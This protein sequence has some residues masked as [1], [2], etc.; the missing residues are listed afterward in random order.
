MNKL[1]IILAFGFWPWSSP[2]V[3]VV[4]AVSETVYPGRRE[5]P[6]HT[7]YDILIVAGKSSKK[8]TVDGLYV[9]EQPCPVTLYSWPEKIKT[10]SF[11]KGDTLLVRAEWFEKRQIP[12][13]EI[14]PSPPGVIRQYEVVLGFKVRKKRKYLP[15]K[16]ITRKPDNIKL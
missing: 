4:R 15:V 1:L 16:G 12:P 10:S 3:E 9:K 5:T 8:L 2:P 14:Q 11:A 13:E 6:V 7:R